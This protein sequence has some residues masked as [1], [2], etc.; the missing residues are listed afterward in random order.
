MTHPQKIAHTQVCLWVEADYFAYKC[1][2]MET[3]R[4][5][6]PIALPCALIESLNLQSTITI[7]ELLP[8]SFNKG[9]NIDLFCFWSLCITNQDL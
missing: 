1:E 7:S 8:L 5:A 9:R 2:Q 4:R 6:L 3:A